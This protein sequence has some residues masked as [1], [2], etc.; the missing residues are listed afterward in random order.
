MPNTGG[1]QNWGYVDVPII[2]PGET[3]DL[4]LV[5]RGASGYLY[6]VNWIDFVGAGRRRGPADDRA[7]DRDG[8]PGRPERRGRLVHVAGRGDA[9]VGG[10]RASTAIGTGAWT[11]YTTP[12]RFAT[13]GIY[14]LD[15]RARKDGLPSAGQSLDVKVDQA[16]P[17][18]TAALE[19]LTSGDTFTGAVRVTLTAADADVGRRRDAVAAGR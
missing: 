15:Y 3:F 2:D 18:T 5:F 13:D 7:A 14:R 6:N 12:V 11:T 17:A 9:D 16:A 19:G 1:F 4:V 8:R 10:R